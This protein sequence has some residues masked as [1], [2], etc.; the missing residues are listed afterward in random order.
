MAEG[1]STSSSLQ[2]ILWNIL[3][4]IFIQLLIFKTV[5]EDKVKIVL[6]S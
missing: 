2:V 4:V 3:K 6:W 1:P 5:N